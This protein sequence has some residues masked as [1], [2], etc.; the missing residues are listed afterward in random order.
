MGR[1]FR[2]YQVIALERRSCG[3]CITLFWHFLCVIAIQ[4]NPIMLDIFIDSRGYYRFRDSRKLVHRWAAEKK[5][6]RKL[7]QGEVVHHVNHNKLDNR[8]SNLYICSSQE[9]HL[10]FHMLDTLFR[11]RL[12][13]AIRKH[14]HQL[15]YQYTDLIRNGEPYV[16]KSL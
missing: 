10:R 12:D 9:E 4:T 14:L 1:K 15:L 2:L 3:W 5:L 16:V 8:P 7:R 6:G 11:V 13:D